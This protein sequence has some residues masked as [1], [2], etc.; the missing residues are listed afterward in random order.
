MS[1]PTL[2]EV[3]YIGVIVASFIPERAIQYPVSRGQI[4]SA[5][6]PK[7]MDGRTVNYSFSI[8]LLVYY[9]HSHNRMY[10]QISHS[11]R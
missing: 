1:Q 10:Q 2:T 9:A 6:L 3:T 5:D 8:M 11:G 4:I 7:W